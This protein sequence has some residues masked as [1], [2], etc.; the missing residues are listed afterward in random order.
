MVYLLLLGATQVFADDN[1]RS[2]HWAEGVYFPPTPGPAVIPTNTLAIKPIQ[3]KINRHNP[4]SILDRGGV[5]SQSSQPQ[6]SL[7]CPAGRYDPYPSLVD[8]G[9]SYFPRQTGNYVPEYYSPIP[10][11][12]YDPD[13]YKGNYRDSGH[14]GIG[15]Y[16]GDD[17]RIYISSKA[18]EHYENQYRSGPYNDEDNRYRNSYYNDRHDLGMAGA[19]SGYSS[20]YDGRG[21]RRSAK[22]YPYVPGL[23][24][25]MYRED[26]G[27][28]AQ[29]WEW[30]LPISESAL[31]FLP[32]W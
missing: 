15:G 22:K 3:Q 19:R 7:G 26:Y 5:Y 32:L 9:R 11:Q 24:R 10:Y 12:E 31:P 2:R 28:V 30:I 20:T 18:D 23:A 1:E 8:P 4:W 17:Y 13:V 27:N 16:P 14:A 29:P 6:Q 25:Q 21:Y